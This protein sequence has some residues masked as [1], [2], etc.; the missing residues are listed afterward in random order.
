MNKPFCHNDLP[1]LF[2]ERMKKLCGEDWTTQ[3]EAPLYR[4]L[5]L[6][7]LKATEEDVLPAI[8]KWNPK[9]IPFSS[10]GYSIDSTCKVGAEPLHHAGAYYMQE[11]SAM[12]AVAIL[13]PK[14]GESVLDLCAAPGGK[15]TQIAASLNGKGLLWCNEYVSSRAKILCQ[16]LERLGVTNAIVSSLDTTPLCDALEGFFDAVLVDAPCSGEGMFRKEEA[17]LTQWSLENIQLCAERGASILHNAS[18]AVCPGGRILFSTCTF[19]PEE[20]EIQIAKFLSSH[21]NFYLVDIHTSF[22]REGFSYDKVKNFTDNLPALKDDLTKCRR[23]FPQDG[24]EGHFLALLQRDCEENSKEYP[25]YTPSKSNNIDSIM[26]ALKEW[27]TVIPEGILE[28]FGTTWKL[29]PPNY[30]KPKN[31]PIFTAGVPVAE[32]CKNRLEPT[33]AL[34]MAYGH[35]AKNKIYLKDTDLNAKAFIHGESFPC[36]AA[37]GYCAVMIKNVCVGYGKVSNGTLKN[38]Y[39]KG[40]RTI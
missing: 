36:D 30:Y 23:I 40:L 38:H 31:I 25:T 19:A 8:A 37:N 34:F 4:G 7:P 14:P 11:P 28:C 6:N 17:A 18:K 3:Y 9:P 26:N 35:L 27:L 12:S 10:L 16:N 29:L 24:G 22:G 5:R 13:N 20:D 21:P 33:H 1:P 2:L 32:V 15:S 39:P